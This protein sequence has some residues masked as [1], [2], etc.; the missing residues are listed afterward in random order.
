MTGWRDVSERALLPTA[1][2]AC[3]AMAVYAA[4]SAGAVAQSGS[5]SP[6]PQADSCGLNDEAGGTIVQEI[7]SPIYPAGEYPVQLPPM[8]FLGAPNNLPNP[9][10]QGAH[11]GRL[12]D[13]RHWGSTAGIATGPDN[14][15]WVIDRCGLRGAGGTLCLES[16][17]DPILQFDTAGR[18]LQS[19]GRGAIVSPHKITVDRD[20]NVW[21]ADN[22]TA[23]GRGHQVLKFNPSGEL[24]MTLGT[25]GVAGTGH[26]EFDAPTEVAIAPNGDIYVADGH[27]RGS[28]ETGN[29]RIMKF[30]RNGE[31]IKTWGRKGM[32][33]G[34]FDEIHSLELDSR[35]WLFVADRQNNRIQVFDA[36]G[37]FIDQWFQFGRPS[38][39]HIDENDVIYVADSES[40]DARTNIGRP[41]MDR[42]YNPGTRRGI[43][44]GSA[45]DGSVHHF[46][47]D[48]C[49]YPYP[50]ISS[51]A[52]G[53]TVDADG[54]VYG[55]EW[56][57]TV[58]KY[59]RR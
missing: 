33:P 18:L 1:I 38:G 58:R 34:E 29:A 4:G 12:P 13:G 22:G 41:L 23:P 3:A 11:W 52:E 48:P 42:R 7:I 49:A 43:R 50:G 15:I 20:G 54:N 46:I 36:E 2:I 9:F 39:I 45:R 31:F 17:L 56:L 59:V 47:P 24:V 6:G 5:G 16:A 14:T 10:E 30:D 27:S 44:I 28:G 40:R 55:A 32:G 21:I 35:G 37:N 8:S 57:G 53:V 25:P 51:M 19:F 26:D